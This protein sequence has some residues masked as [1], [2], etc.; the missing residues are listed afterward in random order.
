MKKL[1]ESIRNIFDRK[2]YNT[3][4]IIAGKIVTVPVIA[5][6]IQ[7]AARQAEILC[8]DCGFVIDVAAC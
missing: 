4:M 3:T 1:I 2:T 6:D 7:S 8:D 5:K